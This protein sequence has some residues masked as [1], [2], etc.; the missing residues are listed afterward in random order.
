[1]TAEEHPVR[2]FHDASVETAR[3]SAL[4]KRYD[5]DYDKALEAQRRGEEVSESEMNDANDPM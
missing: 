4:L 3:F 1:M 2:S 5:G